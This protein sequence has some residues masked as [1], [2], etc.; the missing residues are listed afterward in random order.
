MSDLT[1]ISWT[2]SNWLQNFPLHRETVLDYFSLSPFYDRSSINEQARMSNL[3]ATQIAGMEG[4]RFVLHAAREETPSLFVIRKI[5]Q[6]GQAVETAPQNL[7]SSYYVLNGIIYQAPTVDAVIQA[8]L[9]SCLHHVQQAAMHMH[10]LSTLHRDRQAS[11]VPKAVEASPEVVFRRVDNML[12]AS[13][14][15]TLQ[16]QQASKKA[17]EESSQQDLER[18][19]QESSQQSSK[20]TT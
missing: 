7:I 8:R 15:K 1:K 2:D 11:K 6:S 9:G 5:F 19:T 18:T 10:A 17:T 14:A 20:Q 13:L 16:A 4:I 3:L 12:D